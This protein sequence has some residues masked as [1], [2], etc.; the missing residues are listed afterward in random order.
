MKKL[1]RKA[2]NKGLKGQPAYHPFPKGHIPWNK[3]KHHSEETKKKI[4]DTNKGKHIT[5]QHIEI[6]RLANTGRVPWNKGRKWS[7]EEIEARRHPA[8]N[9]GIPFSDES[10]RKMSLSKMKTG[11]INHVG[12]IR[13][14][15]EGHPRAIRHGKYVLE[16]HL[17]M[18]KHIGRYLE[19]K[20]VVH[21][22]NGNKSDNRIENLELMTRSEHTKHH[23]LGHKKLPPAALPTT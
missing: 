22:V 7:A 2:W 6:L 17:V 1:T 12:Y 20:E 16:H 13:V 4:S 14:R 9:K 3:G 19:P 10:K 8:W 11:R 23:R 18:E 21:H 5:A 15:T